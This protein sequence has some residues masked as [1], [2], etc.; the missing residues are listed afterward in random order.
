MDGLN[1]EEIKFFF[2]VLK[3]LE[4]PKILISYILVLYLPIVRT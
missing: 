4:F 2:N 1:D 3:K